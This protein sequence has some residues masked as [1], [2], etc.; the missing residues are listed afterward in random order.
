MPRPSIPI[1]SGDRIRKVA[2]GIID[3]EGLD[4][5][6]MRKLATELGV[7][8]PSLYGHVATKD[9][10]LHEIA[11]AVLEDVDVSGFED[12]DWR[13][14]LVVSARSYRAALSQHPNIVPFL[15][16]GPAG[17]DASLR[18]LDVM[19]GALVDAGW[20]RR[21]ATMI[22]A[23][24]MYLVFGAALSTFSN[25]FSTDASV[26]Q[27]RYPHLDKAHLLSTV[28]GELDRDSFELALSAFVEG[29]GLL[30]VSA[31]LEVRE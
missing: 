7:R 19:H 18:R 16:Y 24:L 15:A 2:L 10:L 9:D 4:G 20:P 12:G 25:G 26:Y 31:D 5:L 21:H 11:S 14:G 1:L 13:R 28:A 29:L 6:S 30:R 22:A 27:G 23:S 3:R 17:R 8:A